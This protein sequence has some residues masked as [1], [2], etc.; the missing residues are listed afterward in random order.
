MN[1]NFVL[2]TSF[3]W[4]VRWI[5]MCAIV[6]KRYCLLLTHLCRDHLQF[7]WMPMFKINIMDQDLLCKWFYRFSRSPLCCTVDTPLQYTSCTQLRQVS[8]QQQPPHRKW[9]NLIEKTTTNKWTKWSNVVGE[10]NKM[11]QSWFILHQQHFFFLNKILLA[12]SALVTFIF[13]A[14]RMN[15]PKKQ[16]TGEVY[17]RPETND[18]IL[19]TNLL[20]FFLINW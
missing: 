18:N 12:E 9:L 8:Q 13:T 4:M 15:M 3:I 7:T 16:V 5:H 19:S 17:S 14:Q 11:N 6:L 2:L 1:R 20:I 10:K